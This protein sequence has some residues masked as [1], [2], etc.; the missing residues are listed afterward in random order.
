MTN[1]L[2]KQNEKIVMR[3][4]TN[5]MIVNIILSVFKVAAGFIAHSGAMIPTVSILHQTCSAPSSLW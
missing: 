1:D 3:V 2:A 4:S 5:S